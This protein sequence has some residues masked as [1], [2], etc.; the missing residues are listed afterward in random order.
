MARGLLVE[1]N[2]QIQ[3]DTRRREQAARQAARAQAGAQ[4]T[5]EQAARQAEQARVQAQR[6]SAAEQKN[7]EQETKRLHVEAMEAE[8]SARNAALAVTYGEIDSILADTLAVDDYVDLETLRR[9]VEH[10]PFEPGRV[11]TPNPRPGPIRAPLRPEF[12]APHGEPKKFSLTLGAKK[13]YAALLAYAQAGHAEAIRGG[14]V[15][16]ATI[17]GRTATM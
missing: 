16:V 11:A 13:R 6:A 9:V 10:P 14:E 2:R 17:P 8:V 5:A 3:Q 4:R 7:A 1:I 12:V 15:G